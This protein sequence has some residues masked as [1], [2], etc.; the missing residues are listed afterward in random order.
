MAFLAFILFL[1]NSVCMGFVVYQYL[2]KRAPGVVALPWGIGH[3]V[4]AQYFL[5][6]FLDTVTKAG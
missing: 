1:A 5:W 2:E 6:D 4:I 3:L